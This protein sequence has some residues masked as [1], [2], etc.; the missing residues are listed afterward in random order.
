M[1]I[2]LIWLQTCLFQNIKI[3]MNYCSS[4][5]EFVVGIFGQ[6]AD[7]KVSYTVKY[8]VYPFSKLQVLNLTMDDFMGSNDSKFL[9]LDACF[10][11][12]YLLQY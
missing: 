10:L 12:N 6:K 5:G 3:C 9:S 8:V 4:F 7:S 11:V 2:S 1:F